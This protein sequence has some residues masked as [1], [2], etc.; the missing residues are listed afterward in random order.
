[1]SAPKLTSRQLRRHFERAKRQIQH[2][3]DAGILPTTVERFESL[4]H[5]VNPGK[6]TNALDPDDVV[7]LEA[8]I[9]AWLYHK[10]TRQ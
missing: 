10:K 5:Y 6:Y 8:L 2:D 9:D 1:M 7:Q 4:R 3:F